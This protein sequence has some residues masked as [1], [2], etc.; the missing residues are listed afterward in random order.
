LAA[1]L[2]QFLT[3]NLL[4]AS[5]MIIRVRNKPNHSDARGSSFAAANLLE[6]VTLRKTLVAATGLP[7]RTSCNHRRCNFCK[8]L[9]MRPETYK[10]VQNLRSLSK[11]HPDCKMPITIEVAGRGAT[12]GQRGIERG[13]A[14]LSNTIGLSHSDVQQG[15][16]ASPRRCRCLL[17]PCPCL[18]KD[19]RYTQLSSI[20][21]FTTTMLAELTAFQLHATTN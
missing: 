13:T 7:T 15:D 14:F 21:Q 9:C 10:T 6:V 4:F 18:W 5:R 1:K 20:N 3:W 2:A 8:N 17:R 19:R 16:P 11:N 12:V